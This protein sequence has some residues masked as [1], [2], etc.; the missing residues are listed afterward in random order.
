M[1]T[2]I[3]L[4]VIVN[5]LSA[6]KDSSRVNGRSYHRC[7]VRFTYTQNASMSNKLFTYGNSEWEQRYKAEII[8]YTC[9]L[10]YLSIQFEH[11]AEFSI[12]V[13]LVLGLIQK[14]KWRWSSTSFS[15]SDANRC[16]R[17]WISHGTSHQTSA[18]RWSQ[19]EQY[20]MMTNLPCAFRKVE[21]HH[22]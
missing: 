9:G 20:L 16:F 15:V 13:N 17:C 6:V 14:I 21:L 7:L 4:H 11:Y 19:Y 1:T 5:F 22:L 10:L 8:D 18:S 2:A 3:N 12:Y